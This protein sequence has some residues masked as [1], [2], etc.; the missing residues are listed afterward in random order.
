MILLEASFSHKKPRV[1]FAYFTERTSQPCYVYL[2]KNKS[3]RRFWKP[4]CFQIINSAEM[5]IFWSMPYPPISLNDK[6]QCDKKTVPC[7]ISSLV[8]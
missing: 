5:D 1:Y 3:E 2:Y 7:M 4:R 8:S 6:A